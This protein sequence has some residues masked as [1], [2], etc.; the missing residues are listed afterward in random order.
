MAYMMHSEHVTVLLCEIGLPSTDICTDMHSKM[1][2]PIG[3]ES[4][5]DLVCLPLSICDI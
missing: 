2:F 5:H 1:H 3:V 4:V